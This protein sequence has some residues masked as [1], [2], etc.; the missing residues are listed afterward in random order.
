MKNKE[1]IIQLEN[2]IKQWESRAKDWQDDADHWEKSET[3]NKLIGLAARNACAARVD[4][5]ETCIGHIKDL[6]NETSE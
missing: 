1:L 3:T 6:I 5:Y 2:L 4:V